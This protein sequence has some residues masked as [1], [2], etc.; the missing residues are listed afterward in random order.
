MV[1]GPPCQTFLQM[2][3]MCCCLLLVACSRQKS[4]NGIQGYAEG[5]FVYISPPL[6]GVISSLDV[7]RGDQVTSGQVLFTIDPTTAKAARDEASRKIEEARA[8]LRD[9]QLGKRPTE[10]ISLEAQM[11][12][13]Q[14]A[15]A[16]AMK[17]YDR[18]K[19][20]FQN[21]TISAE[22][23]DQARSS[24]EQSQQKVQQLQA[25]LATG[26]QGARENQIEAAD[27][28]VRA[29]EASLRQTEWNLAQTTQTAPSSAAVFDTYFRPGEDVPPAK[30]V[31]SLLPPENIHVRVFVPEQTLGTVQAGTSAT[32][33]ADGSSR[34]VSG[35]ISFISPRAE[36]TPP[37]LYTKTARQ[38]FSYMVEI[39]FE[40]ADSKTLHPGQPVE[41]TFSSKPGQ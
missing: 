13:A 15:L 5:D 4:S 3:T 22:E 37:V 29:L 36:F 12:Q 23:R 8:T 2:L 34:P 14:A 30:P 7:S 40:P 28:N 32:V 6:G 26:K 35:W 38:K 27:A 39:S 21:H 25:D 10:I 11:K 41:V 19:V 31:V 9:L 16:L 20:L 1:N 33:I 24:A 18:Q 17:N